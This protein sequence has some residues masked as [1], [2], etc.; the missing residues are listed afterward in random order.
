M[1]YLLCALTL[2]CGICISKPILASSNEE[3]YKYISGGANFIDKAPC[4][5]VGYRQRWE[6]N[7]GWDSAITYATLGVS[8]HFSWHGVVHYYLNDDKN[9]PYIGVGARIGEML[10]NA[11]RRWMGMISADYVIGKVLM[12]EGHS[13]HF[14]E[15]HIAS[16]TGWR[17]HT[18]HNKG[19]NASPFVFLTYGVAF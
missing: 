1:R 18:T 13:S 11:D 7:L 4:L 8:H 16:P 9:A 6:G 17:D 14:V 10:Y 2:M 12:S 19:V 15:M 5:S 3:S